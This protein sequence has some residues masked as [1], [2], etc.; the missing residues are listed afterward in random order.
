MFLILEHQ[1]H[2][3]GWP[4]KEKCKKSR[5]RKQTKKLHC[6]RFATGKEIINGYEEDVPGKRNH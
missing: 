1:K 6:C 2:Q 4:L 5:N 3:Y